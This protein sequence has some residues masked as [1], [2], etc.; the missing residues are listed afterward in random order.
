MIRLSR[1]VLCDRWRESKL[2]GRLSRIPGQISSFRPP[3]AVLLC[4]SWET[5]R[6]SSYPLSG[7]IPLRAIKARVPEGLQK[8]CFARMSQSSFLGGQSLVMLSY[9]F[10]FI[11]HTEVF[12][13]PFAICFGSSSPCVRDNA[14][15]FHLRQTRYCRFLG[16]SLV[17]C[18]LF[19]SNRVVR[20][21]LSLF[22]GSW[23]PL[24]TL[25]TRILK[26][27]QLAD[28]NRCPVLMSLGGVAGRGSPV[29]LCLPSSTFSFYVQ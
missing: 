11:W 17:S 5:S 3:F 23:R 28:W 13:K 2:G 29:P 19:F 20:F 1:S 25:K 6:D 21:E 26:K 7:C 4:F 24:I 14:A 9:R 16:I 18:R 15:N 12:L 22:P 27:A 10:L 8:R